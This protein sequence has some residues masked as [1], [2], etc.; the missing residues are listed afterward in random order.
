MMIGCTEIKFT[1]PQPA[2]GEELSQFPSEIQGL[3]LTQDGSDSLRVDA[4]HFEFG[5]VDGHL[6][7]SATLSGDSLLFLKENL[8]FFNY[9]HNGIWSVMIVD[10]QNLPELKVSMFIAEDTVKLKR[11]SEIA[12]LDKQ[13]DETGAII[14][15]IANLSG[16]Q[17]EKLMNEKLYT[18]VMVLS[19][20]E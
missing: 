1:E 20:I 8:L 11:V 16:A 5:R 3:F 14:S 15:Y 4:D 6:H 12:S 10:P 7:V 13:V 2:G 9:G 19:K 17:F 18:E